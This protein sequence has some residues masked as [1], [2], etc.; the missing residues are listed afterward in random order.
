MLN[1]SRVVV[2]GKKLLSS[3]GKVKC[4]VGIAVVTFSP[5]RYLHSALHCFCLFC[6]FYRHTIVEYPF[7]SWGI[8]IPC[9]AYIQVSYKYILPFVPKC[10]HILCFCLISRLPLNPPLFS[11]VSLFI[12]SISIMIFPPC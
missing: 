4:W 7:L 12:S 2:H 8:A 1:V 6:F 3:L 5:P 9:M 10:P 11:S